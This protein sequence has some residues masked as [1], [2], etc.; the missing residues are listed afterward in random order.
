MS[1][2]GSKAV[3]SEDELGEKWDRCI[4]DS[5]LKT[6]EPEFLSSIM[7]LIDAHLA[8]QYSGHAHGLSLESILVLNNFL[9]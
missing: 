5:I 9:R 4:A 1:D 3:P 6:G 7:F 8:N 2:T